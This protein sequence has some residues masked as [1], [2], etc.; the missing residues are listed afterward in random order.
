MLDV[1]PNGGRLDSKPILNSREVAPG[2]HPVADIFNLT[3]EEF[4]L[5][6]HGL[7][8]LLRHD[9]LYVFLS[10]G[11]FQTVADHLDRGGN[12]SE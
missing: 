11:R 9:T 6:A 1:T 12:E 2:R 8:L 5:L 7:E 10:R 4:D 3:T